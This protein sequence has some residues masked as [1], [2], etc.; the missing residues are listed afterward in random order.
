MRQAIRLLVILLLAVATANLGH[1]AEALSQIEHSVIRLHILADS[2]E[3]GAQMQK[4]LVRDALLEHAADWIPQDAD[5]EAGCEAIRRQLPAIRKTA[6]ETLRAAGCPDAVSVCL[7]KTAFPERAYGKLTLPAGEYLALRVEIGRAAGQNWWCVM[8]PAM[9][10]P[11]AAESEPEEMLT[12]EACDM[13]LH[14]EQYEVRLKCVDT[15]R[16]AMRK[17]REFTEQ[18][19]AASPEGK[20]ASPQTDEISAISSRSCYCSRS[21]YCRSYY[22]SRSRTEES[23]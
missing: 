18:A 16:S 15:V 22:R 14:P 6:L 2:D 8:Y 13:A 12:A 4:L 20:T 23:E 3:T 19:E 7:E 5:F 9:C 17:L 10:I 11:A 1:T 21:R